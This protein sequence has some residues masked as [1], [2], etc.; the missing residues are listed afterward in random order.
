MQNQIKPLREFIG[1]LLNN[2]IS[3]D[4]RTWLDGITHKLSNDPDN[5]QLYMAFSRAS[6]K[7]GKAF[8]N[9][10]PETKQKAAGL[11]KNL[12][13]EHWTLDVA[14]RVYLILNGPVDDKD[15]FAEMLEKL[16]GSADMREQIAIYC[17][18]PVFPY[19][20]ALKAR[21]AEGIRTNIKHVFDAV[22]LNNPYPRDYLDR[23]AWNQMVLKAVFMQRP[24]YRITGLDERANPELATMLHDFAH[25]RWAAGRDVMP[26]LWRP[27]PA[28]I[29]DAILKD[30]EQILHY[31]TDTE[32]KAVLL[33]CKQSPV[34]QATD[35]AGKYMHEFIN[36][37]ETITWKN[38]SDTY[39]SR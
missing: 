7:T 8:L 10:S 1:D 29:N 26:E 24:L 5:K 21:A 28:F 31:G 4:A 17:G 39:F 20:E 27:V 34:K 14:V 6:R 37:N 9:P 30:M 18:L 16:A 3:D 12:I 33:A 15:S 23:Q 11:R 38:I 22:A 32:K 35:L 36:E 25:E 2:C 19:P 13:I